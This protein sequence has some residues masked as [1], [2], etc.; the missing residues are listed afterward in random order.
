M[1]VL[2]RHHAYKKFEGTP[3]WQELD[4]AITRL[5]ENGDIEEL[6]AREFIVGYLCQVLTAAKRD[7]AATAA[8]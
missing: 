2:P 6:T 5:I 7:S 3:L 4:A 1:T 8:E